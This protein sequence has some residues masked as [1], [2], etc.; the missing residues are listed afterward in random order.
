MSEKMLKV[1]KKGEIFTSK[2][3]RRRAKIRE[4]GKVKATIVNDR[5]VIEPIPSIEGIIQSPKLTIK[6]KDAELLS[7]EAQMEEGW[8]EMDG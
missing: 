6:A 7:E 8:T 4:G 3:L 1:G 2:E 5:L